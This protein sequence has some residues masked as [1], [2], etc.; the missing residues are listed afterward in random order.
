[1]VARP[2][3]QLARQKVSD[4][5]LGPI[6]E[7]WD[8][9]RDAAVGPDLGGIEIEFVTPARSRVLTEVDDLLEDE[10]KDVNIEPEPDADQT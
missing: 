5:R 4:V 1:M 9:G 10:L 2:L 7:A 6:G 8:Q 3:N